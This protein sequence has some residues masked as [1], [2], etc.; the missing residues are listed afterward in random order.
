MNDQPKVTPRELLAVGLWVVLWDATL[1]RNDGFSGAAL[2][3]LLGPVLLTLGAP[4]RQINRDLVVLGAMAAV[5][6]ARL[7]WCGDAATV[8]IGLL[9]IVAFAMTLGGRRPYVLHGVGFL[10]QTA[11]AGGVGLSQYAKKL[12]PFNVDLKRLPIASIVFPAIALF[13]FGAIFVFANPDLRSSVGGF[14]EQGWETLCVLLESWS[15]G[16]TV[17]WGFCAWWAAGMLRPLTWRDPTVTAEI[18]EEEEVEEKAAPAESSM[19][20]AYRNTLASVCLL[21]AVYL[22]FEFQTLWFREFPEGFY[23]SG[24]AHEGAAWLTIALGLATVVISVILRGR[25]LGDP[26]TPRLRKLAWLW[27]V[28]NFVLAAAV[29]NRLF[30]YIGFN[31]M[32]RMRMVGL[33]G[34]ST[35][36]AGLVLVLWKIARNRGFFWLVQRDLW[37]LAAAIYLY[38]VTPVDMLVC[39]YN[40]DRVAAGELAP[41]VQVARHST[42]AEGLLMLR[43]LLNCDDP[44]IRE[45]VRAMF[46]REELAAGS[47]KDGWAY[48]QWVRRRL[49]D[50][51]AAEGHL[52]K[53]YLDDDKRRWEAER[54]F[55]DYTYQWW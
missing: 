14:L 30:I 31:G 9:L 22:V 28:E 23:Y 29:Y 39:S 7:L 43:P 38:A 10:V 3:M 5:L 52:W 53:K 37:A 34:I 13:V 21:F 2:S 16:E 36:V 8:A 12:K 44:I 46:A 35:V 27:S 40:A 25:L 15:L 48:F 20:A 11:F 49:L 1:Y 45:G 24:Y 17:F 41:A 32:T 51:F 6:A 50:V 33:F 19:Y 26:R 42:S 4:R 18:V 47:W 54:A 55:R